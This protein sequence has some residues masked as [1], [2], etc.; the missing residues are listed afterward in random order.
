MKPGVIKNKTSMLD[1]WGFYAFCSANITPKH[2]T[3]LLNPSLARM[4]HGVAPHKATHCEGSPVVPEPNSRTWWPSKC[5][6]C[7]QIQAA[8]S[9]LPHQGLSNAW[10]SWG[11]WTRRTMSGSPSMAGNLSSIS[12][13]SSSQLAASNS[14]KQ[15][16]IRKG[17]ISGCFQGYL[18]GSFGDPS[19]T[20]I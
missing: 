4:L 8:R 14:S 12:E 2:S 16:R 15:R 20:Q 7:L 6:G 19:I 17:M 13:D 10:P 18:E 11:H 9:A 1:M 5:E 3:H